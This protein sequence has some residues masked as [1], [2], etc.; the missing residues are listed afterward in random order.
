MSDVR[1]FQ[2]GYS[3]H[4]LQH[5]INETIALSNEPVEPSA[6]EAL[7]I[8]RN[9]KHQVEFT[10]N[11]LMEVLTSWNKAYD[12]FTKKASDSSDNDDSNDSM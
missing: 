1:W 4:K 5:I 2:L 7:Q 12:L 9:L 3:T 8:L 10:G 6:L 11:N